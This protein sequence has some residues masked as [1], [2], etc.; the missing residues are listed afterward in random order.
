[1]SPDGRP[2]FRPAAIVCDVDGTITDQEKR[3]GPEVVEALRAV[4][5]RGVPVILCTGNVLPIAH[6]LR[7]A[8]GLTGPVVAENGAMMMH[9]GKITQFGHRKN[10]EPAYRHL[11]EHHPAQLLVTDRWREGEIAIKMCDVEEIKR[12]LAGFDVRV[13]AT[14]F[15]VHLMEPHLSKGVGAR[16]ACELVGIDPSRAAAIGDNEND[17]TVFDVVGYRIAVG[18]ATPGLKARADYVSPREFGQGVADGIH[19][20]GLM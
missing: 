6:G 17:L 5:A 8:I 12:L 20:L 15:A 10:V 3:L 2:P 18:N 11:R 14:G 4:E 1:M 9:D 13:E 7:L 19:H 16:K